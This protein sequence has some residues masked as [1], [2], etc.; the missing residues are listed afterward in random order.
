M[1]LHNFKNLKLNNYR[2]TTM[3]R[4]FQTRIKIM[5]VH[6]L[7][8]VDLKTR[9]QYYDE[10]WEEYLQKA[11]LNMK[12]ELI[13]F[14]IDP[15]N[16]NGQ[17]FRACID[18]LP[19]EPLIIAVNND[20][21]DPGAYPNTLTLFYAEGGKT[22]LIVDPVTESNRTMFVL[23]GKPTSLLHEI[24]PRSDE[25]CYNPSHDLYVTTKGTLR[26]K[27]MSLNSC[28]EDC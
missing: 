26:E 8:A 15:E 12:E 7:A 28:P 27:V 11:R 10:D 2:Q 13:D 18:C 16:K 5:R 17:E 21:C 22:E 14:R 20:A 19:D 23:P 1:W 6:D 25:F 3:G 9:S 4:I 24:G